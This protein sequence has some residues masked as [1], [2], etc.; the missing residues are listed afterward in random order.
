LLILS[1][2]ES[3]IILAQL[4]GVVKGVLVCGL[5][6]ILGE[7][8]EGVGGAPGVPQ[9]SPGPKISDRPFVGEMSFVYNLS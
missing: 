7:L 5:S 1:Q 3:G 2:F 4:A 8:R 9:Y 6:Q